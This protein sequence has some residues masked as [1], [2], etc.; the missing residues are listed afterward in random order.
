MHSPFARERKRAEE[1]KCEPSASSS[2]D[3]G[4]DVSRGGS[5]AESSSEL[6]DTQAAGSGEELL[7]LPTKGAPATCGGSSSATHVDDLLPDV[8]LCPLQREALSKIISTLDV[9]N[10]SVVVTNPLKPGDECAPPTRLDSLGAASARGR[11]HQ[12]G[13]AGGCHSIALGTGDGP[14][15][16]DRLESRRTHRVPPH[17]TVSTAPLPRHN[18]SI[19]TRTCTFVPRHRR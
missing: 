12:R 10:K 5:H 11:R 17:T 19:H 18:P 3:A 4:T 13:R 14:S 9:A 16:V 2:Y 6:T 15:L 8:G 1:S 7:T